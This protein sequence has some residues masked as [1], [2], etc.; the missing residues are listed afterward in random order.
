MLAR[1]GA[2]AP[3]SRGGDVHRGEA[4]VAERSILK[5]RVREEAFSTLHLAPDAYRLN[6]DALSQS[7]DA[8]GFFCC[9]LLK[10]RLSGPWDASIFLHFCAVLV[11][12]IIFSLGCFASGL[13]TINYDL[14][15]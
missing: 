10:N 1:E 9:C 2:G 3:R 14:Y 11:I 12:R 7:L 13:E 8:L 5:V 4:Q 6:K 15:V